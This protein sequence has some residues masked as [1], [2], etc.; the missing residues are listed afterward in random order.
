MLILASASPR[1]KK[2]LSLAG[3]TFQV[4]PAN[5]DETPLENESPTAYVARIAESKARAAAQT[6]PP[7]SLVIAADTTVA[8]G[9]QIMGKP[10]DAQEAADMLAQLRGRTHQAI[11]AIAVL[12]VQDQILLTDL[13]ATDV[14]MRDYTDEEIQAYIATGDPFD[15]AG[16]YAIQHRGFHPVAHLSGCYANVAGLPLCHLVRTLWKL[17]ISPQADVPRA[18]QAEL[19]YNCPV[20]QDVLQGAL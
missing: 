19:D 7:D 3:W 15:K 13:A 11:T 16:A 12:R 8:D 6:A 9:E 20:Y 4:Q 10:R 2:L 17:G 1:R 14:P 5:V 18:C